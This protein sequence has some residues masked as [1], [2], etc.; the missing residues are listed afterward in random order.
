MIIDGHAH[1]GG[2]YRD[3]KSILQT[4]DNAEV[5]K[6]VICPA[7][8]PT[9]KAYPL[10]DMAEIK[11][12]KD[13]NFQLNKVLRAIG[14]N[15]LIH[16][17]IEKENEHIYELSSQANRRIIQFFWANPMRKGLFDELDSKYSRWNF[18]GI[19]LHQ[20]IHPFN[21]LS[22]DFQTII[23]FA[24]KFRLPVFI[25]P[26]SKND[27]IQIIQVSSQVQASLIIGHLIGL[28]IFIENK[29]LV[30]SNVFFDISCPSFISEDRI[31]KAVNVFGANRVILGSDI[32]YGRHN[33]S[34]IIDKIRKLNLSENQTKLILGGNMA[35]LLN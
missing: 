32:P 20:C 22:S 6:V 31:L 34:Q 21:I 23:E 15:V 26:Y 11:P 28:E 30:G 7:G 5:E 13:L 18:G 4:L 1:C 35:N 29:N 17:F 27:V 19:K 33:L 24:D 2:E 16:R 3:L 12:E 8:A 14:N 9:R 25:H 10:P